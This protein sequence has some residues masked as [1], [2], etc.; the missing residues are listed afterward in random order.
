MDLTVDFAAVG[1]PAGKSVEVFDIWQGKSLGT[2]EL[3][4][5]AANVAMH[6]TAFLRLTPKS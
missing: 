5:T 4:Y 2:H 3:S 6:G 1:L